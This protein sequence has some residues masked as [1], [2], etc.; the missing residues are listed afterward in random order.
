MTSHIVLGSGYGDEGKGLVTDYLA[1]THS[2]HKGLVIRFNGG[3][4]AGHT[5]YKDNGTSHVFSSYG[6]GTFRGWPTYISKYCTVYPSAIL[7]EWTSLISENPKL[8][9]DALC[10]VTTPWDIAYNRFMEELRT[11]SR[12]GSVGVG[13]GATIERHTTT[14]YRLYAQDLWHTG[15]LDHRLDAIGKYYRHK[16]VH[17]HGDA[18]Y[19]AYA[20]ILDDDVS[21]DAASMEADARMLW[22]R[23]VSVVNEKSFLAN[24]IYK[25][26]IFE[27]AQ[28]ILLDMDHGFFP[29]VTRSNTTSKNAMELIKRNGMYHPD[30]YYVTRAYQTRHGNGP[31]TNEKKPENNWITINPNETNQ[32][33]PFQGHFRRAIMDADMLKYAI[34]CDKNYLLSGVANRNL[35]ITCL[36]HM[37]SQ[38][39]SFTSDSFMFTETRPEVVRDTVLHGGGL[40][41]SNCPY[42]S[43]LFSHNSK[44]SLA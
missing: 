14:G 40:F 43:R 26:N 37:P 42:G 7:N 39:C 29:H 12:H 9:I 33:D 4:Q 16:I 30:M 20:K 11:H 44:L 38:L 3:H 25:T 13:F 8:Y 1:L 36:D 6:S 10:P 18:A 2:E 41:T 22:S 19:R 23:G 27:G 35:V 28:G 5:V 21:L 24:Y 31:M 15:A 17:E 34:D 32:T